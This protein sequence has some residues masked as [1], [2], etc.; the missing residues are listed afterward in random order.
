MSAKDWNTMLIWLRR[1]S[2]SSFLDIRVT[3]RPSRKTLPRVGSMS[4]F[5]MRTSVDL[6]DPDRPITTNTSPS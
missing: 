1:I 2:M 3:S 4:R 6:P 5:S